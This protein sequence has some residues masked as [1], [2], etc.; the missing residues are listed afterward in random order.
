LLGEQTRDHDDLD[1]VVGRVDLDRCAAA[2]ADLGFRRDEGAWPGQPARL[3]LRDAAERQVDFHPLVFD[4]RGH[5]WQQIGEDA[6]GF[7]PAG[8]LDASGVVAGRKV[9][10]IAAMLQL[11]H[12]LGYEWRDLDR[13]DLGLLAERFGLPLPPHGD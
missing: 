7:Y 1:L 4:E 9:R 3:V 5:G 13:R 8:E 12:H 10:C 6:W 11:R 2:L